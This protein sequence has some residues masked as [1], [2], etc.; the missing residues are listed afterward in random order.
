MVSRIAVLGFILLTA[1]ACSRLPNVPTAYSS[2]PGLRSEHDAALKAVPGPV[3]PAVPAAAL[4][5]IRIPGTALAR[6]AESPG[7]GQGARVN[8]TDVLAASARA[9]LGWQILRPTELTRPAFV[10]NRDA[11]ARSVAETGTIDAGKRIASFEVSSYDREA[12]MA[13]LEKEGRRAAKPI[14]TGC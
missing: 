4:P 9:R 14:C 8:P 11:L 7:E 6:G 1:G 13:R 5:V 2:L 12:M 3:A 10:R